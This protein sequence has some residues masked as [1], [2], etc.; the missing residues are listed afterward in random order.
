MFGPLEKV[1]L[2]PGRLLVHVLTRPQQVLTGP[3][4]LRPSALVSKRCAFLLPATP[5]AV[6]RF[7]SAEHV[8]EYLNV[9]INQSLPVPAGGN[10]GAAGQGYLGSFSGDRGEPVGPGRPR[11][12][13]GHLWAI[14]VCFGLL[15]CISVSSQPR[16][17][18]NS[19]NKDENVPSAFNARS[20]GGAPT[21]VSRS[22][23]ERE[24]ER[25]VR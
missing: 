3:V 18:S 1:L 19:G 2:R 15:S 7:I 9:G 22:A 11:E 14:K 4:K 24:R 12:S 21:G 8:Q 16:T 25:D 6:V 13:C 10:D 23:R 20:G 17:T 5:T